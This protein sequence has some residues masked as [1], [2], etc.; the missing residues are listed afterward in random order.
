MTSPEPVPP[1]AGPVALIVT[2]DGSTSS[3]TVATSHAAAELAELAELLEE[4]TA[5]AIKALTTPATTTTATAPAIHHRR[6][7]GAPESGGTSGTDHP[8]LLGI[9]PNTRRQDTPQ[10]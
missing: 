2:T 4:L 7:L 3:A 10:A 5:F 9:V 8:A 1:P 6:R